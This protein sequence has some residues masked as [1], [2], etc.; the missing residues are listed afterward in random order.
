[1]CE[2]RQANGKHST[3]H[4]MQFASAVHDLAKL[5]LSA[6]YTNHGSDHTE[7]ALAIGVPQCCPNLVVGFAISNR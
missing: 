7:L 1:M 3:I 6:T 2:S 4:D 5:G